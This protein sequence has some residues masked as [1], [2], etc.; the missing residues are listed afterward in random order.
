MTFIQPD[1][2]K[3]ALENMGVLVKDEADAPHLRMDRWKRGVDTAYTIDVQGVHVH[4]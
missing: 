3:S 4:V 2:I 1:D